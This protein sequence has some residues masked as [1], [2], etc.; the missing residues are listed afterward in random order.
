MSTPTADGTFTAG[1]RLWLEE[2]GVDVG[3]IFQLQARDFCR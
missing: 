1:N 3:E 2:S